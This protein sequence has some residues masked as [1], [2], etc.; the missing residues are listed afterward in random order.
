MKPP[1]EHIKVVARNRKARHSFLVHD[2]LE[3]GI[4]LKGTEVKS[5]RSGE[6]SI[7]EA[8]GRLIKG[9][10]FL[11][12]SNI[13]EYSHGTAANHNPVR[14]RKLLAH[15]R[16]IAKWEK[17]VKEK[18]MTIVPLEVYFRGPL[19]KVKMALV[20]GKKLFDK[21]QDQKTKSA[22]RDMDRAMGRRR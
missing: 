11:M 21:R 19:V 16:E 14:D 13:P 5:L 8:Y 3:C 12:G 20:Q 15:A 4:E 10:L 6:A 7:R 18:G 22:K 17:R 1:E 2:E 9:E